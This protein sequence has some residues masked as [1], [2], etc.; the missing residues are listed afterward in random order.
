MRY[1]SAAVDRLRAQGISVNDE[2]AVWLSP[3]GHAH[4]N[5]LGRYSIASSAPAEGLRELGDI[6]PFA[7]SAAWS[8]ARLGG[9]GFTTG[10]SAGPGRVGCGARV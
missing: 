10:P 6:S 4:L 3:L 5:C 9:R 1:L 2:D 7:A 8:G